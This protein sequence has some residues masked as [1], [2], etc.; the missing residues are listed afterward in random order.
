MFSR[1][2]FLV[3]ASAAIGGLTFSSRSARA[4]AQGTNR[5]SLPPY[6]NSPTPAA[7][8]SLCIQRPAVPLSAPERDGVL[9]EADPD[10]PPPQE[11]VTLRHREQRVQGAA[12]H[13]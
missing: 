4:R 12:V 8:D 11:A 13:Q 6:R 9:A 1:R 5:A 2:G 3:T 7:L 10:R